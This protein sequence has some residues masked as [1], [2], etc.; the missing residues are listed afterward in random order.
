MKRFWFILDNSNPYGPKNFG[1]TSINLDNAKR[2]LKDKLDS[3]GWID[4]SSQIE[5][6]SFIVEDI[7]LQLLD[8]THVVPN[9]GVVTFEGV[10]WPKLNI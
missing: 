1:V 9:M 3:I 5:R 4:E 8:Q 6:T 10:W 2:T 7:D